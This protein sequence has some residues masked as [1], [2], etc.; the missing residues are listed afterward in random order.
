MNA[1]RPVIL[2]CLF[3][4]LGAIQFGCKKKNESTSSGSS[5]AAEQIKGKW[6]CEKDGAIINL[7]FGDKA[8]G[9]WKYGSSGP[10]FEGTYKVID[11]KTLEIPKFGG[12]FE[13][14][15]K[16]ESLSGDKLVLSGFSY[17]SGTYEFTKQDGSGTTAAADTRVLWVHSRG[18]FAKTGAN[19]WD[20]DLIGDGD[21]KGQ[22]FH[23][24]FTEAKRT[25]ALV[26]L[27]DDS[28]KCT[29]QL[30][31]DH[32]TVKFDDNP[33]ERL[34]DGAWAT[35]QS[36]AAKPM[37]KTLLPGQ[38]FGTWIAPKTNEFPYQVLIQFYRMDDLTVKMT[39][40][41]PKP[42][43]R[44]G[45]F[46]LEGNTVTATFMKDGQPERE[47]WTVQ[48]ASEEQLV[49][50]DGRGKTTTLKRLHFNNKGEAIEPP[51]DNP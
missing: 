15:V 12:G 30:L 32:C 48:S 9:S 43:E 7:E 20:E 10:S 27:Y 21:E 22:T 17:K 3:V 23:F 49:I 36:P 25:P 47:T 41:T 1:C 46:K 42:V 39:V 37:G 29:L 35:A 40:R 2:S 6:K 34:Y 28:R 45:T 16:I 33:F 5:Q 24:T 44:E 4:V 13:E 31:A 26:E 38:I 8:T 19:T 11:D 14:K 50:T 18:R 51:G